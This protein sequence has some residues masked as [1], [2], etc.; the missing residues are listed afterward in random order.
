MAQMENLCL[1]FLKLKQ[2]NRFL[3]KSAPETYKHRHQPR[4]GQGV[5]ITRSSHLVRTAPDR[6]LG[7]SK[8]MNESV[9]RLG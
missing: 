9:V 4:R 8:Q 6:R 3:R 5:V 2:D 1:F 7:L